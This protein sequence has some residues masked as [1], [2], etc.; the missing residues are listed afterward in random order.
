[1][2]I[3]TVHI[4]TCNGGQHE[5]FGK[6]LLIS[7]FGMLPWV[8]IDSFGKV[9]RLIDFILL[10]LYKFLSISFM[11]LIVVMILNI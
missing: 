10:Y 7:V 11:G 2:P 4:R 1:M 3:H 9:S 8:H 5:L 6:D